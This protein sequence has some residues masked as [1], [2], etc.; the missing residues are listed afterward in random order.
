MT[1]QK[2]SIRVVSKRTGLS[3]HVIRAWEQ[4]YAVVIPSRTETNRRL[5]SDDDVERLQKL[6]T[7]SEH[8]HSIGRIAR[9]TREQLELLL[10]EEGRPSNN[11]SLKEVGGDSF[12][13]RAIEA[14]IAQDDRL[15]NE[16]I[17]EAAVRLGHSGLLTRFVAPLAERIGELW[18]QGEINAAHEH[19]ATST[20]NSFLLTHIRGFSIP[21]SAPVLVV[22]TPSGQVHELGA[23]MAAAAAAHHGWRVIYLGASLPAHEIAS[24]VLRHK[25]RALALSV[26]YPG[27]DPRLP[28]ELATLREQLPEE[29]PVLIGGRC[30]EDYATSIDKN[31]FHLLGGLDEF[32]EALDDARARGH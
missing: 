10:E 8:G 32:Y 28:G 13:A 16:L 30:A 5:Y 7:L 27:D 15:L 2:H 9:L 14:V 6:R 21:E 26:I 1:D 12:I 31:D 25:A 11:P 20:L 4:R 29:F 23:T 22:G 24:T 18:H 19:L 17:N 3:S